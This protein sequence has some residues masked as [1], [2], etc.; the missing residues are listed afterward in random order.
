VSSKHAAGQLEVA[1]AQI[2][3][4]LQTREVAEHCVALRSPSCSR[5]KA[6]ILPRARAAAAPTVFEVRIGVVQIEVQQCGKATR[7]VTPNPPTAVSLNQS[8]ESRERGQGMR[9]WIVKL[10]TRDTAG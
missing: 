4:R 5:V 8:S 3:E 1:S 6:V 7:A 10:C 9:S 2:G